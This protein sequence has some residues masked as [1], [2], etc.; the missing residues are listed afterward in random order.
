MSY[1]IY[2]EKQG[3]VNALLSKKIATFLG[4]W[5][6]LCSFQ[7]IFQILPDFGVRQSSKIFQSLPDSLT[8][9][10]DHIAG[11]GFDRPQLGF[12]SDMGIIFIGDL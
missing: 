9:R 5:G 11:N 7:D 8:G 4:K 12:F 10:E 1:I 2:T 6:I 3:A